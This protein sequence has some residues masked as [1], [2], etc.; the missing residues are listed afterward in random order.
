VTRYDVTLA[1]AW[2][3]IAHRYADRRQ[4][5]TPPYWR[6]VRWSRWRD[7][8]WMPPHRAYVT[9]LAS[10]T[11]VVA[12]CLAIVV[13]VL[14]TPDVATMVLALLAILFV[15][16]TR[17]G[18]CRPPSR[19]G[20][21][22]ERPRG[23]SHRRR[24]PHDDARRDQLRRPA[25]R[26][27]PRSFGRP[28]GP[29]PREHR[30]HAC[31][32]GRDRAAMLAVVA[33]AVQAP[34]ARY[35]SHRGAPLPPRLHCRSGGPRL[36]RPFRALERSAT[37]VSTVFVLFEQR[38]RSVWLALVLIVGVLFWGRALNVDAPDFVAIGR[39]RQTAARQLR[40]TAIAFLGAGAR[41]ASARRPGDH[42][43]S[44]QRHGMR[45]DVT[46]ADPLHRG[47][48][49][50]VSAKIQAGVCGSRRSWRR[51]RRAAA[52]RSSHDVE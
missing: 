35:R 32:T 15:V 41:G 21:G 10:T 3:G 47:S 42:H 28:F 30:V 9:M 4:W 14:D 36:P 48:R 6:A 37:I 1:A 33:G 50:R 17:V 25:S 19:R 13:G 12:G 43:R 7:A 23:R 38:R 39:L 44:D 45:S 16:V 20:R 8:F 24:V 22:T 46:S 11:T 26:R 52:F 18:A 51:P 49:W 34:A 5:L 2:I 31:G 40:Y 29:R 27:A